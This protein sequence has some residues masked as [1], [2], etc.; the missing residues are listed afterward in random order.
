ML[1]AMRRG[2]QSWVAKI[3]FGI[4]VASFAMWGV[5]DVFRSAGRGSIA[6][7]GSTQIS[8]DEY[9]REFQRE[10]ERVSRDAKQRI[11]PEQARAFGLDRRVLSQMLGGAAIESHAQQLGL[12]MSDQ[13]LIDSIQDDPGLKGPDGKFS[14]P[15]FLARL[16]EMGLSERSFLNLFRKDEL[17]TQVIGSL[18]KGLA[19]PKPTLELANAYNQEKRVIEWIAIDADKAVTVAEPDEAKLKERYEAGKSRFMTQEYRKFQLLTLSIDDLKKSVTV[20]DDEVSKAYAASKDSYDTP[21]QRRVQQLS[22]KDKAAA[23]AA[24]KALRDG[25]KSFGDVAKEIGAKDTD[26]D[27]GLIKKKSLIDAKIADAA[28][29]LEKDTFSDVIDGKFTTVIMR[30]TQIEPGKLET[31][32]GVKDKVRDKLAAEKAKSELQKKRDEIDDSRSAGKTLKEISETLKLPFQEIAAADAKGN[33]PDLKPV[34]ETPDLGKIMSDVFAPD[35]GSNDQGTELASGGYAWIN[36]LSTE[37]PKQLPFEEVKGDVKIDY[38]ASERKRLVA[39]LASKLVERL[40]AGEAMSALEAAAFG[41]AEKTESITRTTLPQGVSEAAVAQAFAF[42]AGKSSSAESAGKSSR[43]V[44]K[45]AEVTPA[46]AATK[47]QLDALSKS[48]QADL[49][50]QA[51]SEYTESLKK[52][53]NAS[54]NEAELKR[55]FGG[56]DQ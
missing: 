30:V 32:E 56:S 10:L 13:A 6:S 11:T 18:V 5:A 20:T 4:L 37:A 29:A 15:T 9:Q 31:F 55:A 25:S 49:T 43:I 42:S 47:E 48:V 44:F 52:S 38:M 26:A 2:A 51:L 21:E 24:L 34:L 22:F 19:V 41:K 45:V 14:Q 7:I 35:A 53:L 8:A 54:V 50:S 3:L 28:F 27:L 12:G 39:E 40:N 1:E 33:G 36:P 23:E 16:R 17:R 46:P